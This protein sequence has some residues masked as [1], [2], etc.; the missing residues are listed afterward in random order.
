[1]SNQKSTEISAIRCPHCSY[2]S[3]CGYLCM[4]GNC[5]RCGA[6]TAYIAFSY[7]G[8]CSREL[9][10]CRECGKEIQ[11]GKVYV[12]HMN[13]FIAEIQGWITDAQEKTNISKSKANPDED[14]F[15]PD[16]SIARW[17]RRIEKLTQL[18]DMMATSTKERM[19]EE[20]SKPKEFDQD[21]Y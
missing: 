13:K 12:D 3:C 16:E 20:L 4:C 10:A 11:E 14:Y 19:I 1:M 15:K 18:R 17:T 2:R 5:E 8:K 9:G 7:C 21:D 6:Q